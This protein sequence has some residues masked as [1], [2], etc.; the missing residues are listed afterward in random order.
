MHFKKRPTGE[1]DPRGGGPGGG[2][3]Q[4]AHDQG[5]AAELLALTL[6]E[7]QC[8]RDCYARGGARRYVPNCGTAL[9]VLTRLG[10]A[11]VL[12]VRLDLQS[13]ATYQLT[14]RGLQH[15]HAADA[16]IAAAP[17]TAAP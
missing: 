1:G 3:T 9:M 7:A 13:R 10:E 8:V 5:A 16:V 4:P 17:R 12:D 2:L 11:G 15:L 6:P 14:V